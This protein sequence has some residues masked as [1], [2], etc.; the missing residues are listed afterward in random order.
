MTAS[1]W[2]A[3]S[4]YVTTAADA[5][6]FM[7]GLWRKNCPAPF[8]TNHH[9]MSVSPV[10]QRPCSPVGVPC[11]GP[12]P[13]VLQHSGSVFLPPND[14]IGHLS[15]AV[16][17]IKSRAPMSRQR[18]TAVCRRA[19]GV[20]TDPASSRAAILLA[21]S[22]WAN[23]AV[24]QSN[25]AEL[26][27]ALLPFPVVCCRS[28]HPEV[29]MSLTIVLRTASAS[30]Q[31]EL[32]SD[33]L[34]RALVPHLCRRGGDWCMTESVVGSIAA[35]LPH[36]DPGVFLDIVPV[37]A[38][39]FV[40]EVRGDDVALTAAKALYFIAQARPREVVPILVSEPAFQ[41]RLASLCFTRFTVALSRIIS[42]AY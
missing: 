33:A 28:A 27:P 14:H 32:Y 2:Y 41:A 6:A 8:L 17:A 23:L 34:V 29:V 35:L 12:A 21:T 26:L 10:P 5:V 25:G 24:R 3:F 15:A 39:L 1:T 37:L 38:R 22:A 13:C 31:R 18:A 36:G 9:Q 7:N 19:L 11:S 40:S 16:T 20:L 30:V 42:D 4:V